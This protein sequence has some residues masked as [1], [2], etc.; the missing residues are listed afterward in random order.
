MGG[1]LSM[2]DA[3]NIIM[4]IQLRIRRL[5]LFATTVKTWMQVEAENA[6]TVQSSLSRLTDRVSSLEMLNRAERG[7]LQQ[8]P[9]L[10]SRS[11]TNLRPTHRGLW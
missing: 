9:A 6:K 10:R 2:C 7:E 3:E 4:K 11:A 1:M 8:T 5:E